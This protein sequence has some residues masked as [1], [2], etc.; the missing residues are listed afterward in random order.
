MKKQIIITFLILALTGGTAFSQN[1]NAKDEPFTLF[2][3]LK[4]ISAMSEEDRLISE[5]TTIFLAK[6]LML[7]DINCVPNN[8]RKLDRQRGAY[9][10]FKDNWGAGGSNASSF[11]VID[12][13]DKYSLLY[14]PSMPYY[15]IETPL[16]LMRVHASKQ[17]TQKKSSIFDL[18]TSGRKE[19]PERDTFVTA[20]STPMIT[21]VLPAK[22]SFRRDIKAVYS[23]KPS[24]GQLVIDA[25]EMPQPS[26]KEPLRLNITRDEAYIIAYVADV[27]KKEVKFV[28]E[29]LNPLDLMA[30]VKKIQASPGPSMLAPRY[31]AKI[32]EV[33][34][35]IETQKQNGELRVY[36]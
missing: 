33:A 32:L 19:L 2:L 36:E 6:E 14:I 10:Y 31:K 17:D 11:N 12:L 35:Q 1:A 30:E 20:L 3:T 8:Y 9:I 26:S 27:V 24:T 7:V 13:N 25:V 21:P 15:H 22:S 18:F 16:P 34:K 4:K 23:K 5:C 29:E 28:D